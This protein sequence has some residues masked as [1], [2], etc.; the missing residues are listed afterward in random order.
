MA[1]GPP[2]GPQPTP[3]SC[4]NVAPILQPMMNTGWLLEIGTVSAAATPDDLVLLLTSTSCPILSTPCRMLPPATPPRNSSTSLPG[5]FTSKDLGQAGRQR[6]TT[7][8]T[9]VDALGGESVTCQV[10]KVHHCC[11]VV[12][13]RTTGLKTSSASGGV[14]CSRNDMLLVLMTFTCGARFSCLHECEQLNVT[15][16]MNNNVPFSPDDDHLWW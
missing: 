12:E 1:P 8:Q 2:T 3:Q 5:L 15:T 9:W 13:N 11:T 14:T 4:P 16:V 10:L 7:N 6:G